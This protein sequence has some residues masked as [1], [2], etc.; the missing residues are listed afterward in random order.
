MPPNTNRGLSIA[1]TWQRLGGRQPATHSCRD[2]IVAALRTLGAEDNSQVFGVREVYEQMARARTRYAESTVF[3][4]MQRMK[5]PAY[6]PP[7]VQLERVGRGGFRI[8]SEVRT[9]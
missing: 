4:T 9:V 8:A 1:G 5:R 6:R 3:R 7:F 2:E